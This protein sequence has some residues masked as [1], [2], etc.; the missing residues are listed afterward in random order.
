[1]GR[2]TVSDRAERSVGMPSRP[3]SAYKRWC[4]L[5]ASVVLVLLQTTLALALTLTEGSPLGCGPA[6]RAAAAP[7]CGSRVNSAS[8]PTTLRSGPGAGSKTVTF[9]TSSGKAWSVTPPKGFDFAKASSEELAFYGVPAEPKSQSSEVH[10]RWLEMI[11]DMKMV[12]PG[13]IVETQDKA[14]SCIAG[15][16][17]SWSGIIALKPS[18]YTPIAYNQ[19][20]SYFYQPQNYHSCPG[21]FAYTYFWTGLGGAGG[22][23]LA[24]NGTSLGRGPD[25]YG[26]VQNPGYLWYETYPGPFTLLRNTSGYTITAPAGGLVLAQT[27][28]YGPSNGQHL[29]YFYWYLYQTNTAYGLW[30]YYTAP[31]SSPGAPGGTSAEFIVERAGGE[32]GGYRLLNYGQLSSIG[33]AVNGQSMATA[34]ANWDTQD[35]VREGRT[36]SKVT[37]VDSGSGAIGTQWMGCY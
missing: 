35:M 6:E 10:S 27:T 33:N 4:A 9:D 21:T 17:S 5:T 32:P 16:C 11:N 34:S 36:L 22:G 1:M 20:T 14:S 30:A 37:A 31:P 13:A 23:V 2:A 29:Y 25:A 3:R 24:Q 15:G 26:T 8:T 12:S 7:G 28:Y 18:Y 19:S